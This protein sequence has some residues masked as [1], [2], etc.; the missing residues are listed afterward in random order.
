MLYYGDEIGMGDDLRLP[1]RDG[2]RTPMQWSDDANAGFAPRS[3]SRLVIP[4]IDNPVNGYRVVNVAAQQGKCDSLLTRVTRLIHVRRCHIAFGRG[5]IEFLQTGNEAIL[6]FI[7]RHGDD[8]ILVVANLSG[9]VQSVVLELPTSVI[10][11][12]L[13]EIV[14][15]VAF[16]AAGRSPYPLALGPYASYWFQCRVPGEML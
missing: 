11:L 6:A 1:D 7:R 14:D 10:G 12:A 8:T 9:S 5:S 15:D 13:V 16:P 3:V 2:V 4:V